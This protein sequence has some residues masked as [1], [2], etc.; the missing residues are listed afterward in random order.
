MNDVRSHSCA[1][2]HAIIYLGVL[3]SQ[4]QNLLWRVKNFVWQFL[5]CIDHQYFDNVFLQ[6]IH[7]RYT[8]LAFTCFC[9]PSFERSQRKSVT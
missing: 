5:F 1:P 7:K 9:L 6:K 4:V 2:T 8:S 3:S